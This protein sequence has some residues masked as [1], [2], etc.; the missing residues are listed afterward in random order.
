M[1]QFATTLP[2]DQ[3][4][5]D[6]YYA[7]TDPSFW[8]RRP[9]Q[10]LVIRSLETSTA[11]PLSKPSIKA[12]LAEA[13]KRETDEIFEDGIESDF[14]RDVT[15]IILNLGEPA[16]DALAGVV[17]YRNVNEE[18]ASESL[19]LLGRMNDSI[20]HARRLW[21][22][23]SALFSGSARIRDAASVGLASLDDPHAIAYIRRAINEESC[24]ELRE[25]MNQVLEQ[26][27]ETLKCLSSSAK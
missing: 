13:F 18:L 17:F 5:F 19:E 14:A 24:A 4:L 23:E 20:T 27:D 3:V 25:D 16:I 9:R 21:L 2:N 11:P 6:D 8:D 7:R 22:L 10:R 1:I 26:L 12:E 15:S